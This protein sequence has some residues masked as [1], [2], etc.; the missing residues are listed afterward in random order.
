MVRLQADSDHL[1]LLLGDLLKKPL[2][3]N[4]LHVVGALASVWPGPLC[5]REGVQL[6]NGLRLSMEGLEVQIMSYTL[7]VAVM[8]KFETEGRK[9][10]IPESVSE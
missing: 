2:P 3:P 5:R 1:L 8:L 10:G 4:E 6:L 9:A 7:E